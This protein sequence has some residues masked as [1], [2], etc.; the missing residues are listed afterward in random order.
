MVY[1][2][3]PV[4]T[5]ST[6]ISRITTC[7]QNFVN[8]EPGACYH[9]HSYTNEICFSSRSRPTVRGYR[10]LHLLIQLDCKYIQRV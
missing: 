2:I 8:I 10:L 5:N 6:E 4:L 3:V 1:V 9:G 7:E